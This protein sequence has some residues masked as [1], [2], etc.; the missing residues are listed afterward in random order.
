MRCQYGIPYAVSQKRGLRD[1]DSLMIESL[2]GDLQSEARVI[3]SR[4]GDDNC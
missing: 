2:E 1:D 4:S 3:Y